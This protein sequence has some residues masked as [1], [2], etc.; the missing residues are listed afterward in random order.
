MLAAE[1]PTSAI[2]YGCGI[3]GELAVFT[4]GENTLQLLDNTV[5]SDLIQSRA[6][7][8]Y[9]NQLVVRAQP[10]WHAAPAPVLCLQ[11]P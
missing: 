3:N 6:M 10:H 2:V 9:N 4:A 1:G 8:W 7:L 11:L 5:N